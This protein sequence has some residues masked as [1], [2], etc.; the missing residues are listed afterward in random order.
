MTQQAAG[1]TAKIG[2]DG[3]LVNWEDASIHVLSHVVHYGSSVFEGVRCYETP[4]GAAVFRLREHMRRLHDSATIYRMPLRWT[5]D[6]LVQATVDTVAGNDLRECY[7]RPIVLRTGEQM[8]FHPIGVPCET[9]IIAWHWKTYLGDGALENGVDVRVSSWRRPAGSTIPTLAKAGGNYLNSQLAKIEAL[10]DGYAEAIVLDVHGQISEGSGE[11]LFLV[12]DGALYTPPL[13]SAV[14]GGITRDSVVRI[15]KEIGLDV[16]V[17]TLPRELLYVAD[18]MFLTGTAA[19]ITPVKSV[20]RVTVG[21]G[22]RGPLTSAIQSR[23]MD[24]AT[25]KVPDAWGWLTRVPQRQ[26]AGT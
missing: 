25:G 10:Q 9:F 3:S 16:H 4:D 20:D 23:F 18:E 19:E 6:E 24:I 21:A 1:R 12:R 22:T 13:A 5:V 7:I 26:G 14:L 11:N 2:R 15:A 17:Q 8:G